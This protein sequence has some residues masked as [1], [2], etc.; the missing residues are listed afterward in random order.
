MESLTGLLTDRLIDPAIIVPA[1]TVT[2]VIVSGFAARVAE[3]VQER[4]SRRRLA[5]N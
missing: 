1:V 5:A 2:G 4:H 3:R